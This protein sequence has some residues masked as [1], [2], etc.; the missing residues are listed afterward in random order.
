MVATALSHLNIAG[1]N[2]T[3]YRVYRGQL[4]RANH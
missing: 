2:Q 1:K 3:A 4:K